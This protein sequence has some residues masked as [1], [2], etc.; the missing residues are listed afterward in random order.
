MN[1]LKPYAYAVYR[2]YCRA[3][4]DCEESEELLTPTEFE[5]D[6]HHDK[7]VANGLYQPLYDVP[8]DMVMVPVEPTPHMTYAA[9]NTDLT[10]FCSSSRQSR[11]HDIAEQVYK[12][13]IKAREV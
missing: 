13:M 9:E 4:D 3:P 5:N 10:K 8:E 11:H 1:E 12:A 7:L 2:V 6:Q